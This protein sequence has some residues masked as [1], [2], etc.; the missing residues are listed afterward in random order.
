MSALGLSA[1]ASADPIAIPSLVGDGVYP[2]AA[3]ILEEQNVRLIA[4]DGHVL[5]VDCATPPQGDIGLLKIWTTD[6]TIGTSGIGLVCFKVTADAG[7][8][9]LEVPG[10]YEIRGDGQ[11]TGTGHEVT[12]ELEDATGEEITV[13]VDPDGSTPV[14]LGADPTAP[15]TMLLQLRAGEG[16]APAVGTQTAIGKLFAVDRMCT[17]TLVAPRWVLSATSCFADDPL[18]PA[19][20]EG[21]PA[22]PGVV[23]FPGHAAAT[24]D[25][26]TPRTGRDLVLARLATPILDITPVALA[27]AAAAT[28]T[29]VGYGRTAVDWVADQQQSAQLSFTGSTAT[30]L[31]STSGPLVCKGM[32]GAPVLSGGK[33]AAVLTQAGQAGCFDLTA[34][35]SAVTATRADDLATWFNAIT[36]TAADHSWSLADTPAGASTGTAVTTASDSVYTGTARPLTATAGATWNVTA[37]DT[38]TPS[39][40]LDGVSGSLATT[41]SAVATDGS[42]TVSAWVK[43]T[44]QPGTVL[45]QDAVNKTGFELS[46]TAGN[47]WQFSVSTEDSRWLSVWQG[48]RSDGD[49]LTVGKWTKLTASFN[50]TDG[51]L[52]LFVDGVEVGRHRNDGNASVSSTGPLRIGAQRSRGTVGSFFG[53][54]VAAVQ[55]WNRVVDPVQAQGPASYYKRLAAPTRFLDTR[56][57]TGGTTGT[58]DLNDS[59]RVQIAGV[60]GVPATGVTAVALNVATVSPQFGSGLVAWPDLTP[61]PLGV[62]LKYRA[63]V[64]TS[65]YMIVPVGSNGYIRL[66]PVWRETFFISQPTDKSTHIL[67]DVSGYFTTDSA[68]TG[69]S[70]YTPVVPVRFADSRTGAGGNTGKVPAGATWNYKVTGATVGTGTVPNGITAVA[71]NITTVSATA[72]GFVTTWEQGQ[73]K[74][75]VSGLQYQ[76]TDVY[77]GMAIIP[78][79]PTTGQFSLSAHQPT[80]VIIDIL[81]YFAPGTS[82]QKY[83]A[84]PSTGLLYTAESGTQAP[85]GGSKTVTPVANMVGANITLVVGLAALSSGGGMVTSYPSATPAPSTSTLNFIV[86]KSVSN[87]T[88]VNAGANGSVAFAVSGSAAHLAVYSD[89]F[90]SNN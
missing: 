14:G 39:V 49:T 67:A 76:P 30:T 44:G 25:W 48:A 81:G 61:Q 68:V 10:V 69:I 73:A 83:H 47:A 24:I 29:A 36:T 1:P 89:G 65:G 42:F 12:A 59:I 75:A 41:A 82:G 90:F 4:G 84:F 57:G 34:T 9:S 51:V 63:G 11:R 31:S 17:A 16:A 55:V 50:K 66:S 37:G 27:T 64:V 56:N 54:Q 38:F 15:P 33:L 58:V 60:N 18:Q 53:G 23:R 35:G 6:E 45:S 19:L 43:P 3:Q 85:A 21:A 62:N 70:S 77:A 28:A 22:R 13:E 7:W 52:K 86:D 8:L 40:A 74:P 88:V 78:V 79:N 87:S 26:V 71:V 72:G 20:T 2:G 80:H 46:S 32:A 5:L